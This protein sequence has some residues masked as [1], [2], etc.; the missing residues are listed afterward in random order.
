MDK[1]IVLRE[2]L[3]ELIDKTILYQYTIP[4]TEKECEDDCY[5][6]SNDNDLVELIYNSIIE[7]SFNEFEMIEYDYSTLFARALTTK[8]KY[9]EW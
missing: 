1:E 7:Y 8:M 4:Y 5:D 6:Y 2:S 9:K 3:K